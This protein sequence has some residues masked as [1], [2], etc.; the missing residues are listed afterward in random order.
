MTKDQLLPFAHFFESEL[1]VLE[2]ETDLRPIALSDGY[3]DLR[4]LTPSFLKDIERLSP[5]G[6]GN[7]FPK[8]IFT[9]VI[10]ESFQILKDQHIRCRLTQGD[11][12]GVEGIGFRLNHTPFGDYLT[13]RSR[14]PLHILGSPRQDTW[15][16]RTKLTLHLEDG[17][18]A[19][20]L[21]RKTG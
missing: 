6:M 19:S 8:F 2:K 20:D 11:G 16:G 9:D 5:F 4:S 12:V 14:R 13:D 18:L 1:K 15:G 21:L 10:V 17:V 3:L 7:P